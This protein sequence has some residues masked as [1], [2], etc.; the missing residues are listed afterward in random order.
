[1]LFTPDF[2][3]IDSGPF[4]PPCS[5]FPM[6]ELGR[7]RLIRVA[8]CPLLAR[9]RLFEWVREVYMALQGQCTNPASTIDATLT[10]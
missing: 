3:S 10:L 9:R 1:M 4:R 6:T 7:C 2:V 5:F 8:I